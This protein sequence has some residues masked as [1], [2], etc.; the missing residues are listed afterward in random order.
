MVFG[1]A[2]G[3]CSGIAFA[4][5]GYALTLARRDFTSLSATVPSRYEVLVEAAHGQRA[6]AVRAGMQH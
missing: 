2:C 6:G 1:I 5:V 4:A 3:C